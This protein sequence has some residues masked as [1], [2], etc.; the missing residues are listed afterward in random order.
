MDVARRFIVVDMERGAGREPRE[1]RVDDATLVEKVRRLAQIG[2]A[3]LICGAVSKQLE[4]MLTAA[5]IQVIPNK[6]GAIDEVI[7]AFVAGELTDQ[8]FLMPGCTGR[9]CRS[10]RARRRE[11]RG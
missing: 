9:R 6:C 7:E 1:E 3:V 11:D 2:S 10:A 4:S 5:G 8:A